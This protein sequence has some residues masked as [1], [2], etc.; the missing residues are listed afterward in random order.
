M[1]TVTFKSGRTV[2]LNEEEYNNFCKTMEA[3]PINFLSYK[4]D[5]GG[6][7]KTINVNE[8]ESIH[9]GL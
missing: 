9:E 5:N 2:V 4:W 8:I 3:K 7:Y 6:Y 1:F